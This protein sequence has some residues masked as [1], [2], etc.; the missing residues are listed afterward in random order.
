MAARAC[1]RQPVGGTFEAPAATKC[2]LHAS[3]P[4]SRPALFVV[5]PEG[6]DATQE[7]ARL[8]PMPAH[9]PV[10]AGDVPDTLPTGGILAWILPAPTVETVTAVR[11]LVPS[12]P[13]LAAAR[14][15]Q[16]TP[17][18][19]VAAVDA[20]VDLAGTPAT[21]RTLLRL[22][23]TP[24]DATDTASR[25][26]TGTWRVEDGHL[27]LE[28]DGDPPVE[29]TLLREVV[30]AD[31]RAA[32]ASGVSSLHHEHL[33]ARDDD[34]VRVVVTGTV[35]VQRQ[36]RT[37]LAGT[38][39]CAVDSRPE[40][41][42]TRDTLT[43]LVDRPTFLHHL[44]AWQGQ[45][46]HRRPF[47]V[48]VV[49]L[50]RLAA[51][52]DAFGHHVGD[53]LL[54]WATERVLAAA[55][56][57]LVARVGNDEF[58]VLLPGDENETAPTVVARRVLADL[59][60]PTSLDGHLLYP[61][62]KAGLA[63]DDP[64]HDVPDGVLRD[65]QS[66][67][68][69]AK[70][71]GAAGPVSFTR[72]MRLRQLASLQLDHD[73]RHAVANGHLRV[74]FQPIVDLTS[75]ATLGFEALLR[76]PHAERGWIS[77]AE[78]VPHAERTGLIL[79]MGRWVL[80]EAA[81]SLVAVRAREPGLADAYVTVNLS[82]VQLHDPGLVDAVREVLDD[83]GLPASSLR[84]ELTENTA[85]QQPERVLEVLRA[86]RAIGVPILIDDFGT[87]YSSLHVLS[88]LPVDVVKVD[89]SF[90]DG[91]G[92]DAR[93]TRV[94]C[95]IVD[96]AESLG[97]RIIAEGVETK[98]QLSWLRR[99]GIDAAQG[100]LLGKPMP[101]THVSARPVPGGPAADA[102]NEG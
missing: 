92:D 47:A 49:D 51:V 96:L 33:V 77:P 91:L 75:G 70:A 63:W 19:A 58:A 3:H 61:S 95:T 26:V 100:Y 99:L 6:A 67:L 73:L 37:L 82:P 55:P 40:R 76:W 20:Q 88:R 46:P 32:T 69:R 94:V 79:P 42:T 56:G 85:M 8:G 4:Q 84:L 31:A 48:L 87:G 34:V 101:P 30:R 50:D 35:D 13:V 28:T 45:G 89:R 38:V 24:A 72:Q 23:G 60:T 15:T 102:P 5:L 43:G 59:S 39:V 11:T 97:M 14:P 62:A 27:H 12:A 41:R 53:R 1:A 25:R 74:H 86:L 65:A 44:A 9:V 71:V 64:S 22:C 83:T 93:K 68:A 10:L 98:E 57:Q 17:D 66:A 80:E 18:E 78:F 81:R 52:N 21:A 16:P 54:R 90:V 2:A 29:L 36:G 7:L